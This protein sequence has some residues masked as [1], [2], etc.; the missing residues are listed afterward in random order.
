MTAPSSPPMIG[1]TQNSQSCSIAPPPTYT[2]TPVLRAGLT[3]VL[4]TGMLMRW[5]RVRHKPMAM[6]AKPYGARLAVEPRI[7]N[8]NIAVS[9]ISATSA[10][11]IEYPPGERMP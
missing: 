6:P 10:D 8:T 4:S 7:T 1:A 11:S 9:T 5:M 2:A 3:E